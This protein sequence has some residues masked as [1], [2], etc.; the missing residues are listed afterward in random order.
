MP[1]VFAALKSQLETSWLVPDGGQF[2]DS[3]TQSA[4]KFAD[5]VVNW[6]SLALSNGV[7]CATA[8]ARKG[9]LQSL[10]AAALS[11]QT[12]QAAGMQLAMAVATYIAGQSFGPGAAL[13]PAAT[14]AAISQLIGV[15][16]DV[17]GDVAQKAQQVAGA[18][19]VL[20]TSTLVAGFPVPA[21]PTPVAPIL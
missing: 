21:F 16:S 8:T 15:F 3:V 13:F 20:A 6:F 5:C 2:P 18:C 9:Q 1:L 12:A 11:A 19:T 10:A 17:N 7:P 14:S 4:Q